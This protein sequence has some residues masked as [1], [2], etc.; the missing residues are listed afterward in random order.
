VRVEWDWRER[1]GSNLTYSTALQHVAP[2]VVVVV[3]LSLLVVQVRTLGAV[4]LQPKRAHTNGDI[5]TGF[6][7]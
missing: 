6:A 7:K 1:F 2:F 5:S 3:V 4:F